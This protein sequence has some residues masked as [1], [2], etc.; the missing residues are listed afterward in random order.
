MDGERPARDR[1]VGD[2][3]KHLWESS[4]AVSVIPL[5]WQHLAYSLS[6]L[7]RISLPQGRP[8]KETPRPGD[9]QT[10]PLKWISLPQGRLVKEMP[11]PGDLQTEALSR[12]WPQPQAGAWRTPWARGRPPGN[13]NVPIASRVLDTPFQYPCCYLLSSVFKMLIPTHTTVR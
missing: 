10:E 13:M 7:K 9:L 11:R 6:G 3:Q 8:V 1:P 12:R 2:K 4:L 5:I